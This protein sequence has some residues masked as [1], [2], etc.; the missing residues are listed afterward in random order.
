VGRLLAA[1]EHMADTIA[2]EARGEPPQSAYLAMLDRLRTDS[3]SA[4]KQ[5]QAKPWTTRARTHALL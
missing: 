5:Q 1:A 2:R 3:A 4:S